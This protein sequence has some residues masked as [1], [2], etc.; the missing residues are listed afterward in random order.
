MAGPE[1]VVVRCR[2]TGLFPSVARAEEDLA[3]RLGNFADSLRAGAQQLSSFQESAEAWLKKLEHLE[4]QLLCACGYKDPENVRSAYS[5]EKG[6]LTEYDVHQMV[7]ALVE[8]I[9][10]P[11]GKLSSKEG[12]VGKLTERVVS[13]QWPPD[14]VAGAKIKKLMVIKREARNVKS[15]SEGL[16]ALKKKIEEDVVQSAAGHHHHHHHHKKKADLE[17]GVASGNSGF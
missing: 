12:A 13:G 10:E 6:H 15:E 14:N 4:D 16:T 8:L 5:Y 1:I 17:G 3:T 11:P 7:E 9:Q 2:F